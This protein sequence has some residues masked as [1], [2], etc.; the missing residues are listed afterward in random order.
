[1]R[2]DTLIP[3]IV[4][5]LFLAIWALTSILNRDGQP[6]PPRPGRAPGTGLGPGPVRTGP[7]TGAGNRIPGQAAPRPASAPL[8]GRAQGPDYRPRRSRPGVRSNR[9]TPARDR[10]PQRPPS[11]ADDAIVYI[12]TISGRGPARNQPAAAPSASGQASAGSRPTR[13][14]RSR[15]GAKGRGGAGNAPAAAQNRGEPETYRA[16]SNMVTQSLA[17]QKTKPLEITPLN[18]PLTGLSSTLSQA[19]AIPDIN[20]VHSGD[21][22]PSLTGVDI[23]KMLGSPG[24]LREIAIL[25]EL[26]QPPLALRRGSADR[27]RGTPRRS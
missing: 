15:R 8:Q 25:T 4:P 12:E 13:G 11:S 27:A 2:I 17:L 9:S 23:R 20:R 22:R 6:L 24:K 5:L 14:A 10:S 7:G 21:S 16:L 3:F 19:T 26:L 1:M 18:A